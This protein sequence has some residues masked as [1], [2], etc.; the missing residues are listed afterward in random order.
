MNR[1][2]EGVTLGRSRSRRAAMSAM[3]ALF[4]LL[5][6]AAVATFSSPVAAAAAPPFSAQ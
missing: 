2:Q 3:P 1:S 6:G 4:L 5:A